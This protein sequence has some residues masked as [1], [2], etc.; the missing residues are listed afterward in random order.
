MGVR[1]VEPVQKRIAGYVIRINGGTSTGGTLLPYDEQIAR[2]TE[3]RAKV[4]AR[5][6]ADLCEMSYEEIQKQCAYWLPNEPAPSVAICKSETAIAEPATPPRHEAPPSDEKPRRRHSRR[7]PRHRFRPAAW[8]SIYLTCYTR[9][10]VNTPI[11]LSQKKL[12]SQNRIPV[13]PSVRVFE[14]ERTNYHIEHERLAGSL[15]IHSKIANVTF[16]RSEARG[17]VYLKGWRGK[18]D[19][20]AFYYGFSTAKAAEDYATKYAKNEAENEARKL[21]R[22]AEKKSKRDNLRASDHWQVGDVAKTLW[23]YDQTNVE[24][25]QVVEVK[26]KSVVVREIKQNCSDNGGPYGGKT[27]PR[28]FDFCG[29][30]ILCP[31]DEHGGF[32]AGPCHGSET[33]PSF[34][35]HCSK[36]EG[37]AVHTSSYA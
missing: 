5:N 34:R 37:K 8:R 23:G 6:M 25:F 15:I 29:P 2:Q 12:P 30:E 10:R 16:A 1:M 19:K 13:A 26:A 35:N 4:D 32:T 7:A 21:S 18:S 11:G 17:R 27:A 9:P 28:R 36:W 33:T 20:P 14:K 31:L 3:I 22:K 24:F